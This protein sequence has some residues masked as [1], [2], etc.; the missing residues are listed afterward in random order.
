MPRF[1]RRNYRSA[2]PKRTP[3][4]LL[5]WYMFMEVGGRR[6]MRKTAWKLDSQQPSGLGP[7]ERSATLPRVGHS[8]KSLA[9]W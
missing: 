9:Q 5:L 2:Y 7:I 3:Q 1:S 8:D 4:K 6:R